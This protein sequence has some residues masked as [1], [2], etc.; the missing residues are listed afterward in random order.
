LLPEIF[1]SW[2][3]HPFE[4]DDKKR[5]ARE[6]RSHIGRVEMTFIP[7][8][9]PSEDRSWPEGLDAAKALFMA[10]VARIIEDGRG[11]VTRLESGTLELRLAT[12]EIYHLGEKAVARIS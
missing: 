7:T 4:F 5:S 11:E 3:P 8:G 10:E 2:L 12:G 1:F 6:Q 9:S